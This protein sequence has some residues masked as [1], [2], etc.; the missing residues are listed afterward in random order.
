MRARF[1]ASSSENSIGRNRV[2]S[3]RETNFAQQAPRAAG[4]TGENRLERDPLFG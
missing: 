3:Q 2:S 4:A 1:V